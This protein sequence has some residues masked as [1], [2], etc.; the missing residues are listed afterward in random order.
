MDQFFHR[1]PGGKHTHK[2]P[3]W[4]GHSKKKTKTW[5]KKNTAW[6]L[7]LKRSIDLTCFQHRQQSTVFLPIVVTFLKKNTWVTLF[8]CFL[9]CLLS[10][11]VL[12]LVGPVRWINSSVGSQEGNTQTHPRWNWHSKT[13]NELLTRPST[14]K[15]FLIQ[16][17]HFWFSHR[18]N[19]FRRLIRSLRSIW[20][21]NHSSWCL[22]EKDASLVIF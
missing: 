13:M 1:Q 3:W 20:Q 10:I 17:N 21:K 7:I 2:H 19:L 16:T 22:D 11:N 6:M 15:S 8:F 9:S 14:N 5:N 4:N 12:L 18:N